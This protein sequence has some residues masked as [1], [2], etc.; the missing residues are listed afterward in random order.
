VTPTPAAEVQQTATPNNL[1]KERSR[2]IGREKELAECA[3]IFAETRMLTL[4]GVG[5]S[6][7]TRLGLRLAESMLDSYPDGVWFIDLAPVESDALVPQVVVSTLGI[8]PEG[9]ESDEAAI[10][11]S[12]AGK[13]SLLFL[14]NTEHL[15]DPSA[16][17]ADRLLAGL[18][19]LKILVTSREG[20]G[21]EGE[22][23]FA[24]RSLR[25]PP[26]DADPDPKALL[27]HEAVRLFVTRAQEAD[28][29]FTLDAGN[30]RTVVDVCRRLDGIPL[31]LELA[32]ARIRALSIDRIASMLDDRFRLLTG[33][34]RSVQR[35]RTLR[36][37]VQWSYDH[38]E[39]EEQEFFVAL[40]VFSGGW[41]LEAAAHIAE[42]DEF[43][44]LDLLT[45]LIDKSLVL[46]ER[47]PS[48]DTR[49][50]MLE[51]LRQF[52][53]DL[54]TTSGRVEA[55]RT[56]HL[57]CYSKWVES[58]RDA[59]RKYYAPDEIRMLQ[60]DM[61]NLRAALTWG[62][63]EKPV[64]AT[65]ITKVLYPLWDQPGHYAEGRR[66]YGRILER[67]DAVEPA[68]RA[69]V[70]GRSGILAFKQGDYAVQ[71]AH[72]EERSRIFEELGDDR[73]F[74][75]ALVLRGTMHAYMGSPEKAF[76]FYERARVVYEALGDE[77]RIG[78][79]ETSTGLASFLLGDYDDARHRFELSLVQA[80]K[81][82]NEDR[83]QVSLGNLALVDVMQGRPADAKRRIRECM[84]SNRK[85][86]NLYGIAL[87]LPALAE[88]TRQEDDVAGA[89]R[90]IG[91]CDALL[92]K[93]DAKLE[94]LERDTYDRASAA[95]RQAIGDEAFEA[96][97]DEGRKL[98][99][100]D[101][102]D[103]A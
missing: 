41:T 15:L 32:A 8:K 95:A 86:G 14:D 36:A 10:I 44:A 53:M 78:R 76:P 20:L 42:A 21:V 31:A 17:L 97:R 7:K 72:Q 77:S 4:T 46:M 5:G 12:L 87:D 64:P 16:D 28:R 48:G 67:G 30:A 62:F 90:W 50:R 51:T 75:Q 1:P 19:D 57:D 98:S 82:G 92:E 23:L 52:G 45:R 25:L 101:I 2:F 88:A 83:I 55:V 33:G 27:S 80:K 49:Y 6:G 59:L 37:A 91:A 54:L 102:V 29:N 93:I 66:W 73:R 24:V 60:G 22:R 71:L 89:A 65:E 58:M 94:A 3:R 26:E 84:Q 70:L 79:L 69:H 99:W 39:P 96:A 38:L 43:R 18:P 9:G 85:Q 34:S 35:H 13:R 81:E 103:Q 100:E 68:E 40:S 74:A 47:T 61:D 63:Q 11:R 56:R